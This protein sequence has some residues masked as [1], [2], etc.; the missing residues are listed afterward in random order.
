[1]RKIIICMFL[2]IMVN[3]AKSQDTMY[4]HMKVGGIT[5]I[6]AANVDSIIFYQKVITPPPPPTNT[7]TDIDGN[8]YHTIA[9]GTQTWMVEN[10]K[11]TKYRNGSSIP[12]VTSSASWISL[13]T[14]AYCNYNNDATNAVLY[15]RL[16]NWYA[17]SDSRNVAP[18][19]WHVPTIAEFTTLAN[20]LGGEG[21]AG[22]SLKEAGTSHWGTNSGA[23]NKSGFTALPGG[24]RGGLTGNFGG[25]G[26]PVGNGYSGN[27]WSTTQQTS[28]NGQL[29]FIYDFQGM[30]HLSYWPMKDGYSIRCIKD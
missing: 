11:T 8:V 18:V 6:A 16:Y 27:W 14:G 7:V 26:V 21:M 9:I 3:V 12:N 24:G 10:L 30:I 29:M 28:A 2:I 15:G 22:I 20:F 17:A 25:I 13:T 1:M 23:T 19:G 5:K 4:V